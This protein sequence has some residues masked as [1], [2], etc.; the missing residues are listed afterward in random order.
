MMGR[1]TVDQSQLFY[2]FSLE[3]GIPGAAP[4]APHQSDRDADI[5]GALGQAGTFLQ[6]DRPP[7]R[8]A[9]RDLHEDAP[10]MPAPS[11]VRRSSINRATSARRSRCALR[12]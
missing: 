5:G 7:S 4:P 2:L 8:K 1:Q 3:K 6:R 10:I 12:T 11:W 9:T